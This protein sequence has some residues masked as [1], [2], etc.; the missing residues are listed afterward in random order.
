[1]INGG[2]FPECSPMELLYHH[3]FSSQLMP[4]FYHNDKN[5]IT[6][7]KW[8]TDNIIIAG[9]KFLKMAHSNMGGLQHPILYDKLAFEIQRGELIQIL[10]VSS[11]QWITVSN[12]GSQP[13]QVNVYDIL[14]SDSIYSHTKKQI[15]AILFSLFK[16]NMVGVIVVSL[17]WLLPHH[18]LLVKIHLK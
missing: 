14:L 17:H 15:A 10:N 13:G 8:L 5:C 7:G 4:L 3:Q 9:Q 1:M 11:S 18:F 12:I 2:F 16:F 6:G